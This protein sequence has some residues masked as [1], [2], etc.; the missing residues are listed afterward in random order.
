MIDM[1]EAVIAELNNEGL[2]SGDNNKESILKDDKILG[3]NSNNDNK[4]SASNEAQTADRSKQRAVLVHVKLVEIYSK[5]ATD[6]TNFCMFAP[7]TGTTL[8]WLGLVTGL[9]ILVDISLNFSN[10]LNP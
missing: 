7:S 2:E 1:F 6:L 5:T 10:L 4:N 9:V 3:F 8:V